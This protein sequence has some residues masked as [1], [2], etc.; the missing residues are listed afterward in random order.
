MKTA[1][2]MRFAPAN[3]KNEGDRRE[4]AIC[5]FEGIKRVK[6]DSKAYNVASDI[7]VGNRKI[8]VKASKFSLMSGSLCEGYTTFEEIW[9]LYE[10]KCHSNEWA[11]ITKD[12][13]AYF[14]N[15]AEFKDFVFQFCVTEKESEKNGGAVKI[16]C[17]TETQK[18]INWLQSRVS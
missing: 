12:Y 8:S 4:W 6:H 2:I 5:G 13:T 17:R 15:K 7:E 11:Y 1:N 14:M 18:M 9:K 10:T 3:V 16:R